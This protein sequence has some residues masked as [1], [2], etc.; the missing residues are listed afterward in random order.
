MLTYAY[1]TKY[2]NSGFNTFE[3]FVFFAVGIGFSVMSRRR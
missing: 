2:D 1:A 3:L